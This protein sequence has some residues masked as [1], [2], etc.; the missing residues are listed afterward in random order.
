MYFSNSHNSLY[1]GHQLY[2]VILFIVANV[3]PMPYF[4]DKT[5][6]P[7]VLASQFYQEKESFWHMASNILN[8]PKPKVRN[9]PYGH[10]VLLSPLLKW[11][12][13][14]YSVIV[15]RGNKSLK[16]KARIFLNSKH[17]FFNFVS[18]PLFNIAPI[19]P[20]VKQPML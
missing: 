5:S 2:R 8:K 15:H 20:L 11:A 1:V 12:F 13:S 19:G 9:I 7:P 16:V 4:Q 10:C 18:S 6:D 14:I 17:S 3:S